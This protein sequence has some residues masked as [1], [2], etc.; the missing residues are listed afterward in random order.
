MTEKR[1]SA[2]AWCV[3]FANLGLM[4][5]PPVHDVFV[6]G[7]MPLALTYFFGS[8]LILI[9]SMLVLRARDAHAGEE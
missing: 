7:S 1:I 3:L 4:L 5:L 9:A 2:F 6:H 8:G